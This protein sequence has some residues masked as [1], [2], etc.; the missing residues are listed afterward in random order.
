MKNQEKKY[1]TNMKKNLKK[2][3]PVNFPQVRRFYQN[4]QEI[5]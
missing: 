3:N 2:L 4:Y 5:I 1:I